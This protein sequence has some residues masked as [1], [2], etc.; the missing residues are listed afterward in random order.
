MKKQSVAQ[1]T[2][3]LVLAGLVTK[4]L[5][6]VNRVIVTRLLAEDAIGI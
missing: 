6:V 3:I 1:G 4:V 5:G 2:M